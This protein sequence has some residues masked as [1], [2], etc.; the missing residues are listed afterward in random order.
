MDRAFRIPFQPYG[1]PQP[2]QLS[3]FTVPLD[4]QL[5]ILEAQLDLAVELRRNVSMHNV[6]STQ[7]TGDLLNKMKAKHGRE[8]LR[9]N[10]CLHSCG[11]SA[12]MVSEIQVGGYHAR[13]RLSGVGVTH[14][15]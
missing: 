8:W 9:I 10:V 5:A 12:E 14:D 7:A 15:A 11:L 1:A 13:L 2:R 6:K 3:P 4:H